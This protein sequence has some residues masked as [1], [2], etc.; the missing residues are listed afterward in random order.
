MTTKEAWYYFYLKQNVFELNTEFEK[1]HVLFW[2]SCFLFFFFNCFDRIV[3][4]QLRLPAVL[5][6]SDRVG[7]EAPGGQGH[8]AQGPG[9]QKLPGGQKLLA[10][11]IRSRT[12]LQPL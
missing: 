3:C 1:S 12:V 6:H 11:D 10:E 5:C 4:P 7:H 2:F 9:R 8:R